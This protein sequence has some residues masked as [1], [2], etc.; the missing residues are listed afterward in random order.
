M[1]PVRRN[2]SLPEG[3]ISYLEWEAEL[4]A[5]VLIWSHA[6]GFNASTYKSLLQPLAGSFRIIAWDMRG[7]GLTDLPLDKS[8]LTGWRVF[9]DDLLRFIDA[10]DVKPKVIAGHSFGATASLLAAAVRP[11]VTDSLVLA[12]PVM[13][14]DGLALKAR[15]ARLLGRA[16]KV[17]PLVAM[18]LRRRSQF[19]SREDAVKGF[20]G[21][22]AFKTWPTETLADYVETGLVPDGDGFRLSCTPEWEAAAFGVYPFR[23]AHLGSAVRVPVTILA[24][25]VNSTTNESVLNKFIKRHR[26]TRV[27]RVEGA[28]H[29]LPMENPETVR[30]EIFRAAGPAPPSP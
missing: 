1:E 23:L 29:F 21:R 3:T 24:G 11:H 12:E 4:R 14:P 22:G 30:A 26:N 15:I 20:T 25:T 27:V 19:R 8:L 17:I 5:P 28:S 7:H 2:I 18:T 13:P 6:N 10:L 16:D 9:R